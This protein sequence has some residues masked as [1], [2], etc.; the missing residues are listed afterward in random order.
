[1]QTKRN[2]T[3]PIDRRTHSSTVGGRDEVVDSI[4]RKLIKPRNESQSS[5][6]G[7]KIPTQHELAP[8]MRNN[9]QRATDNDYIFE[10]LPD[11]ELVAQ[12]AISSILSSKDMVT[13]A[14]NYDCQSNDL[15][16]ELKSEMIRLVKTHFDD[17]YKLPTYLYDILYDVMFKTGSYAA[18][19]IPETSVDAIINDG[20]NTRVGTEEFKA[21]LRKSFRRRGLLGPIDTERTSGVGLEALGLDGPKSATDDQMIIRFENE[22]L[23]PIHLTD[24]PDTVKLQRIQQTLTKRHVAAA[25]NVSVESGGEV[26]Y[27][28]NSFKTPLYRTKTVED[29]KRA[30]DSDRPSIGHPLIMHLPSESV[31]PVHVPGDFKVHVGYLVLLDNTGNPVSRHDL[32]NNTTAWAWMNGDASSQL[33]KDAAE[34]LG[35][36]TDKQEQWTIS[37]LNNCYADLVSDK[38]IRSLNNGVYGDSVTIARPQ[39]VYRIMMARSLARKNTQILYIPSEQLT[40]FALDYHKDG[41]GRSMT[42]K[43]RVVAAARSAI[44]FATMQGSILNA[45]RNLQYDIILDPDDREPEKTIDDVQYRVSQGFA[46]RIPFTGSIKDVESYFANAGISFNIEGNAHYP[47]SKTAVS[48]I[49]PDYKIPAKD[50]SDD[51]ARQHYRGFGADPD[52]IMTPESIEF[53]TQ[54]VSKDLIATKQICKNQEKIAPHLTHFVKTYIISSGP[55]LKKLA[56]LIK[57]HYES[58]ES[59]LREGETGHYINDFL[60]SLTVTLPPPDMSMLASQ[61]NA[62]EDEEQAI[63]KMVDL[64]LDEELLGESVGF[65]VRRAKSVIA[66]HLKRNWLRKNAVKED[67]IDLFEN[68]ENRA[69][70]VQIIGNENVKI[71]EVVSMI[72]KRVDSRVKTVVENIEMPEGVGGGGFGSDDFGG[73][74]EFGGS[75]DDEFG[76]GADEDFGGDDGGFDDD[77]DMDF[78]SDTADGGAEEPDDVDDEPL[79]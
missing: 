18:A 5:Q 51:L 29:M 47:S 68:E 37:H 10:V 1:M 56:E 48:D 54:V 59:K 69:E 57:E 28:R 78:G 32:M 76:E 44:A 23:A 34:G 13:T 70:L 30:E 19:I 25:Y 15:P 55:L 17:E 42:D 50:I 24:N 3:S 27:D 33:I 45:T 52:L 11:L 63:D 36:G 20:N 8:I 35:L 79:A 14:I 60:S 62:F 22:K 16:L 65:D 46:S 6:S 12:V 43:T 38:L 72:M 73:D 67:L 71:T 77:A 21:E 49:T 31:I 39:E 9:I 66:N 75:G 4:V 61:L 53:A 74:D 7:A 64:W 40:Y 26:V 58:G 2:G 41:T